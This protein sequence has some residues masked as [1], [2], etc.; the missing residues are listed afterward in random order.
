VAEHEGIILGLDQQGWRRDRRQVV[1]AGGTAVIVLGVAVAVQRRGEAAVEIPEGTHAVQWSEALQGTEVV[2]QPLALEALLF[3]PH[4]G[5]HRLHEMRLVDAG[6]AEA[7]AIGT[8]VQAERHGHRN[9]LA[10]RA[11]GCHFAHVLEQYVAAQRVADRMQRRHGPAGLQMPDH[12]GEIIAG[13]GMIGARQQV[14]FARAAAP[15][16]RDARPALRA[17]L[18]LQTEHVKRIRRAGQPV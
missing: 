16:D 8:L 7:D 2:Q 11:T 15:V 14:R 6:E 1:A 13:A 12:F 9:R 17:Q 18:L 5:D 10:Q 4:V 3:V